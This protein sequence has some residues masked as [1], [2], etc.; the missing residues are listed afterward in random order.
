VG[1]DTRGRNHNC[2]RHIFPRKSA[3]K[4]FLPSHCIDGRV[5][6][7]AVLEEILNGLDA[8]DIGYVP[9]EEYR[10]PCMNLK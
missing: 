2:I 6:S 5:S 1:R 9:V 4:S 7:K 10:H 3:R 8:S